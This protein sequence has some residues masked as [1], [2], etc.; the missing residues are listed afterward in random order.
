MFLSEK[1]CYLDLHRTGSVQLQKMFKIKVP[2]GKITGNHNRA[3]EKV[4]NSR[5][6]FVGSIRNPWD[7]YVSVWS[8]GCD[9]TG[10]SFKRH[11]N[12]FF[13]SNLGFKINPFFATIIFL[14]QF[15]KP[16]EKWKALYS[17]N[18]SKKNF[19]KWLNMILK[20]R[21]YDEEAGYGLSSIKKQCGL[22]TYKYL[23]LFSTDTSL[24]FQRNKHMSY[25]EIE[26]FDK[27]N[28]LINYFIR[29][30]SLVKDFCDFLNTINIIV[31]KDEFDFFCNLEKSNFS[32]KRELFNYYYDKETIQLI[33]Q[34]D[35]LIIEKHGYSFNNIRN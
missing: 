7:W 4:I 23:G 3:S 10:Y 8:K 17:D 5:R 18:K 29:T 27:K 26:E 16:T 28:N 34:M 21:I 9:H 11:T 13:F 32:K 22:Y 2:E 12:K 1:F 24:L 33:E 6:V 31:T 20:E 35:R 25:K 14:S 19:R 15:F 30:E